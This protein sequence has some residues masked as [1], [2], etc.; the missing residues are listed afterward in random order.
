MTG[1]FLNALGILIGGLW[2]LALRK[3]LSPRA[4]NFFRSAL[5]AFSVFVGLLDLG[6][7]SI[8]TEGHERAA[9]AAT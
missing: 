2:G 3:P 1:A 6:G 9:G 5:G 4:Q 8:A 7:G